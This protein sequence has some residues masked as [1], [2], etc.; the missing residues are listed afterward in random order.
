MEFTV[1]GRRQGDGNA[2]SA[3]QLPVLWGE[4]S[5]V[6]AILYISQFA[7]C[8]CFSPLWSIHSHSQ[9]YKATENASGEMAWSDDIWLLH[10]KRTNSRASWDE[11]L[12][13]KVSG[14]RLEQQQP[15]WWWSSF[16]ARKTVWQRG[17]TGRHWEWRRIQDHFHLCYSSSTH[18]SWR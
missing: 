13:D 7:L 1:H 14:K 8:H 3:L 16:G 6:P 15:F 17:D 4:T 5:S 2:K 10:Q 18:C 12:W 9:S 11:P